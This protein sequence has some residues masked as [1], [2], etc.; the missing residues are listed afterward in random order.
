MPSSDTDYSAVRKT[1]KPAVTVGQ[2]DTL[3]L[4]R[5]ELQDLRPLAGFTQFTWLSLSMNQIEDV[6]P[7]RS[8]SLGNNPIEDISPLA[9]L[10]EL[11]ALTHPKPVQMLP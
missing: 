9:H 3:V 8:L 4:E 6:T 7:L 5:L 1:T 11:E 10:H 2:E